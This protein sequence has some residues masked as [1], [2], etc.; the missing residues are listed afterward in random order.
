MQSIE[1]EALNKYLKN[2]EFFRKNHPSLYEKITAFDQA[3]E[4]GY[5][6]PKYELEYKEEGYFDVYEPKTGNWLYGMDSNR[7]AEIIAESIDYRKVDNLF[8]AFREFTLNDELAK[9][10]EA[11]PLTESSLSTIAPVVHYVKKVT[12]KQK[13]LMKKIYKFIFFG[14]G[15][16]LHI[17]KVHEKIKAT[18]YLIVEDDLEL[19]RLS[20]FVTD[21]EY[22]TKEG[23]TLFFAVFEDE[24]NFRRIA[25]AFLQEMFPY[26]HYL[27]YFL[28]LSHGTEKIKIFQSVI[29]SLDYM[30]FPHSA[31]LEVYLRPYEYLLEHYKFVDIGRLNKCEVFQNRPLLVLAAGPSLERNIEWVKQNQDRFVIMSVTAVMSLL[32]KHGV[33]PDILVHVD[34]FQASMKHLEKVKSIEFFN[35]TIALFASFTYPDF[36]KAFKKE[37]VYIFQAAA[38][39]KEGFMQVTA[40]NVGIM[41]YILAILFGS[42]SIYSLGLDLAL[43]SETGSTHTSDHVHAKRLDVD[44]TLELEESLDYHETVLKIPGNFRDE[45]PSTPAFISALE[46]LRGIT[47]AIQKED[48]SIYNLSDGALVEG[49]MPKQIEKFKPDMLAQM[50]KDTIRKTIKDCFDRYASDHLTVSELRNLRRRIAHAQKMLGLLENFRSRKFSSIDQ[51]H[52]ELLGLMIDLLDTE[53]KDA[54]I[55]LTDV[56]SVY[57]QLVGSYVFDFINTAGID[58]P[59]QHI[60][61]LNK[62]FITQFIRLLEYYKEYLENFLKEYEGKKEV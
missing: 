59:K 62:I 45:V 11:L 43:D 6:Q 53:A 56:I 58:N 42:K 9:K 8:E 44:H 14:V 36:A 28:L 1:Q 5:Y 25:I 39:I 19:F 10:Y 17:T 48:Q 52:Y 24:K 22:L 33:K 35:D 16:G 21:Y 38:Q 12:D 27:K 46:E 41:S 55:D 31:V 32:E 29:L 7:H 15:L 60:K 2:L 26:N 23:A 13:D 57:I 50:D 3:V 34:G 4:R 30:K 37:N 51:Y 40:S 61:K 54:S 20:M 47:V 18:T 49:S